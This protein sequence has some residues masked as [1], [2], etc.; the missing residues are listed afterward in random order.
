METERHIDRQT[1]T[2]KQT[3][4]DKEIDSTRQ[5]LSDT[6]TWRHKYRVEKETEK[7]ERETVGD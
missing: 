6:Q 7:T 2:E 5:T 4:R 3:Q 1:G